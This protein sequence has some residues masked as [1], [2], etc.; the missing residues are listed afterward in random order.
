MVGLREL[1]AFI[2][3]TL[4]VTASLFLSRAASRPTREELHDLGQG[5]ILGSYCTNLLFGVRTE[6]VRSACRDWTHHRVGMAILC[7]AVA[8]QIAVLIAPVMIEVYLWL[9]VSVALLTAVL[10]WAAGRFISSRL[11]VACLK[12]AIE[13][14]LQRFAELHP[15]GGKRWSDASKAHL[16]LTDQIQRLLRGAERDSAVGSFLKSLIGRGLIPP[17]HEPE[18]KR[19]V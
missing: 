2:G 16:E 1:V 11:T 4:S 3:M 7:L 13:A 14:E 15:A 19:Q 18:E 8:A 10:A 9:A 5:T 6:L 12:S 17:R